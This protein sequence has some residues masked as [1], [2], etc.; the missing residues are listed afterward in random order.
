MYRI[1]TLRIRQ[2]GI[3]ILIET[4]QIVKFFEDK[5]G[6]ILKGNSLHAALKRMPNAI[7]IYPHP[8]KNAT[9]LYLKKISK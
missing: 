3:P 5:F 7:E 2:A 1:G 4:S 6:W 9:N 8:S